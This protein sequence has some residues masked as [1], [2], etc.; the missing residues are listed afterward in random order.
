MWSTFLKEMEARV[1]ISDPT[2]YQV[3]NHGIAR[4]V[5]D[6]CLPLKVFVGHVIWLADKCDYIFIPVLR[7]SQKKVLNCSRFLGLPDVAKAVVP[8]SPPILEI[9]FDMNRGRSFLYQQIFSL[10]R[11]F[12]ADPAKIIMAACAAWETHLDYLELMVNLKITYNDATR[13][14][15]GTPASGSKLTR[16]EEKSDSITVGLIGHPY[17]LNDETINHRLLTILKRFDVSIITPEMLTIAELTQGLKYMNTDAYW[18]AEEEVVGAGGHYLSNGLDGIIG[19]MAFGC[20]PDSLMMHLVQRQA[21]VQNIPYMC[22]SLDEHTAETGI[23]TRLEAFLDMIKRRSLRRSS[24]N[25]Y[26]FSSYR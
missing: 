14:L 8:E 23:I 15:E 24:S 17:I 20:G 21:Q 9:E 3:I 22:L 18:V 26:H 7:S 12:D 13:I 6:T 10:G 5:S 16:L 25:A 2:T 1:I 4:V 11:H 19:V